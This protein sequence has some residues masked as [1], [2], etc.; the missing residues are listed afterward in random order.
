MDIK[1]QDRTR[2]DTLDI[3]SRT[4][5]MLTLWISSLGQDISRYFRLV[6]QYFNQFV[7]IIN[8]QHGPVPP[9]TTNHHVNHVILTDIDICCLSVWIWGETGK[10]L[11]DWL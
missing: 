9:N 3:K 10:I 6:A 7:Q 4:G 2:V 8:P 11:V 1:D 5:H